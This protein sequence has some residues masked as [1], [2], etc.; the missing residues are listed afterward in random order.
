LDCFLGSGTTLIACEQLGRICHGME[1][2]PKYADV[3]VQRW[4]TYT[5]RKAERI[6]Q[7]APTPEEVIIGN[8]PA[9]AH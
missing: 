9:A 4:E 6:R 5:R 8:A 1:I 3:V 7:P 2:E